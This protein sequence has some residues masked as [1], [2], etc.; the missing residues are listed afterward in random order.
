MRDD[1]ERPLLLAATLAVFRV[2]NEWVLAA[3]LRGKSV[4]TQLAW[5]LLQGIWT[6]P[7]SAPS[8]V[9]RRP[10]AKKGSR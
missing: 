9:R 4:D 3:L 10:S 7:A 5:R 1:V 6:K 8:R 2:F